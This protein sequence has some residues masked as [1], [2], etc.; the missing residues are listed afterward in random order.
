MA[1][2]IWTTYAAAIAVAALQ[3]G[4]DPEAGRAQPET[5]LA[6]GSPAALIQQHD[7]WSA[8]APRDMSGRLP[9]HAIVASGATPRYVG[10]DLTGKALDQVFA[11]D[12]HDLVVYAF[13]R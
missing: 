3:L 4:A 8:E 9:G 6:P 2:G 11:G 7:C 13:C 10:S 12:D 1:L 5:P